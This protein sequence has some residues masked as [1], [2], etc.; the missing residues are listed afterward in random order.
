MERRGFVAAVLS[1]LATGCTGVPG[2]DGE[3]STPAYSEGMPVAALSGF[4]Y[5]DAAEIRKHDRAQLTDYAAP[6]AFLRLGTVEKSDLTEVFSFGNR[7]GTSVALGSFEVGEAV[8]ALSAAGFTESDRHAGFRT[9][10]KDTDVAVAVAEETIF[11][12]VHGL[13]AVEKALGARNGDRRTASETDEGFGI[14]VE[15][16]GR[17]T[18]VS[19][20]RTHDDEVGEVARGE[21]F[22]FGREDADFV[23]LY[24][25]KDSEAAEKSVEAARE[26]GSEGLRVVSAEADGRMVRLGGKVPVR[27]L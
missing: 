6:R 23:R 26:Y 4:N 11:K 25:F 1:V 12:S 22:A 20:K 5:Y 8:E 2:I 21:R 7:R 10:E 13:S 16:L 19:G 24:V 18:L 3:G 15:E 9:L 14:L 17:A 27:L